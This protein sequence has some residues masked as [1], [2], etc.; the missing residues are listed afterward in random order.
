MKFDK[1]DTIH[2]LSFLDLKL[3]WDPTR[4]CSI[5]RGDHEKSR[6]GCAR[7]FML[8]AQIMRRPRAYIVDFWPTGHRPLVKKI[9]QVWGGVRFLFGLSPKKVMK[10]WVFCFWVVWIIHKTKIVFRILKMF[11]MNT[12]D[13]HFFFLF[14]LVGAQKLKPSK[15]DS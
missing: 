2:T 10:R 5:R 4:R 14:V 8:V 13:L 1:F 15:I 6:P 11:P 7:S 12:N 9:S 3:Y